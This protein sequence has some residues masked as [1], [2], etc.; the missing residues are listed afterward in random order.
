MSTAI[1]VLTS[2]VNKQWRQLRV[3]QH[4]WLTEYIPNHHCDYFIRC[5]NLN[6]RV[7]PLLPIITSRN[8]ILILYVLCS[9]FQWVHSNR[10]FVGIWISCEPA[11]CTWWDHSSCLR[12]GII[13]LYSPS[14]CNLPRSYFN[15]VTTSLEPE[16]PRH[17]FCLARN[18]IM[19][20][21]LCLAFR[22]CLILWYS[23]ISLYSHR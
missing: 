4:R 14:V 23:S 8:L 7:S 13:C 11:R 5:L 1:C 6:V 2:D 16:I 12:I 17:F 9:A 10:G 18:A 3:S 20:T 21:Y 22:F 15:R 19:W